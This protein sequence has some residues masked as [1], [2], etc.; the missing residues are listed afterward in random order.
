MQILG[1]DGLPV[2]DRLA[3]LTVLFAVRF[4]ICNAN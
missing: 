2:V 1:V 3:G 4:D